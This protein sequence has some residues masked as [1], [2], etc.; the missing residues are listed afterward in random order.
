M[1]HLKTDYP[2]IFSL[3]LRLNPFQSNTTAVIS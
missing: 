2:Y 1:R 3:S